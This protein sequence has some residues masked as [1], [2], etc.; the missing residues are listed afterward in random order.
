MKNRTKFFAF[1]L[2]ILIMMLSCVTAFAEDN[3]IEDPMRPATSITGSYN[4]RTW[5]LDATA[6]SSTKIQSTGT[7]ATEE[8]MKL[9]FNPTFRYQSYDGYVY[10]AGNE[11]ALDYGS[12]FT[13][14]LTKSY[15]VSQAA[16][17]FYIDENHTIPY[18]QILP[19]TATF[20]KCKYSLR[21]DSTTVGSLTV[22]Y[23]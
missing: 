17:Y 9:K 13:N 2:A 18:S 23:S 1:F 19:T 5:T 16:A 20:S 12:F 3:E 22:Y 15:T 10:L 8:Y 6:G 4:G 14:S 21:L 7:Y 11:Y